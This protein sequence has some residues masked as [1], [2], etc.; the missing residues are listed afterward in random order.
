MKNNPQGLKNMQLWSPSYV[1]NHMEEFIKDLNPEDLKKIEHQSLLN[2]SYFQNAFSLSEIEVMQ[3]EKK[4]VQKKIEETIT[5]MKEGT[6]PP[7]LIDYRLFAIIAPENYP[8]VIDYFNVLL[9]SCLKEKQF[10]D[11]TYKETDWDYHVH[12]EYNITNEEMMKKK[13]SILKDAILLMFLPT[14]NEMDIE[15]VKEK[16]GWEIKEY[17]GILEDYKGMKISKNQ[18]QKDMDL[19]QKIYQKIQK[20]VPLEKIGKELNCTESYIHRLLETHLSEEQFNAVKELFQEKNR[21]RTAHIANTIQSLTEFISNGIDVG[22]N[23]I[24]FTMLDYY[25]I[26]K[27]Q[28]N[29]IL[30]FMKQNSK[31]DSR[32]E[33]IKK[34]KIKKF[35]SNKNPLGKIIK[36]ED[37]SNWNQTF[38]NSTGTYEMKDYIDQVL[39]ELEK[40]KIPAHRS[41]AEIA[42]KRM[43]RGE[44]IYPF[45]SDSQKEEEETVEDLIN[46]MKQEEKEKNITKT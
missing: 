42:F 7:Q 17:K 11:Y 38:I 43:V 27:L 20:K 21:Q 6:I 26:T 40:R 19:T 32:E 33:A 14:I 24:S 44:P 4:L 37:E 41:L 5:Q 9:S 23:H 35:L 1:I 2:R 28:P 36:K 39:A 31:S 18:I 30:D 12:S 34:S 46:S 45:L 16:L 22:D 15:E 3:E 8:I 10:T 13:T 25:S 29:T